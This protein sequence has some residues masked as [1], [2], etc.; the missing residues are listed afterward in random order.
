MCSVCVSG[1]GGEWVGGCFYAVPPPPC[2]A[3]MI[4]ERRYMHYSVVVLQSVIT[5]Y[6]SPSTERL[7]LRRRHP[8]SSS[9]HLSTPVFDGIY[10]PKV[11]AG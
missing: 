10:L 3:K 2:A 4:K 5:I 6:M 1:G 8:L 9:S 11:N 7:A